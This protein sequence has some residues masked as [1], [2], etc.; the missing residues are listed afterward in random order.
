MNKEDM[1][2]PSPGAF[3]VADSAERSTQSKN[4]SML[5]RQY[6]RYIVD[7]TTAC[8][9]SAPCSCRVNEAPSVGRAC[10]CVRISQHRHHLQLLSA[11]QAQSLPALVV[12]GE[13][14]H[15]AGRGGGSLPASI[16]LHQLSWTLHFVSS[17]SLAHTHT[18]IAHGRAS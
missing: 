12:G 11:H 17:H 3:D 8:C 2:Q 6:R 5:A 7:N 13:K 16:S 10:R 9:K 18:L 14:V 15:G 4:D 1:V